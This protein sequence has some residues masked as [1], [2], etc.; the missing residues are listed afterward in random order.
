MTDREQE[1]QNRIAIAK[2]EERQLAD[3]NMIVELTK[4]LWWILMSLV[5]AIV[6]KLLDLFG[7]LFNGTP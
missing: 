2:L 1:I 4:K 3:H 7:G 6:T 5:V